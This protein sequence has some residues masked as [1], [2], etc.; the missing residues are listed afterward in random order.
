MALSATIVWETRPGSGNDNNGG[1][2]KPGASGSDFSQQNSPQYALSGIAT[3]GAGATFLTA[4]AAAD[5]VGNVL[6]VISGTNFTVGFYEVV[7]V[8][9]GV[10]VTV[11]RSLASGVGAS[12]VINIGGALESMAVLISAMVTDNSAYVKGTN[13]HTI[14]TGLTLSS[15]AVRLKFYGYTTTRGDNGLATITTATNSTNLVTYPTSTT[16]GYQWENFK[17]T[18]TAS[19]RAFGHTA[20]TGGSCYHV[21]MV[22]CAFD[23]FS[24]A[25]N[26]R[27]ST[28]HTLPFLLMIGCEVKNSTTQGLDLSGPFTLFLCYVHD[29]TGNG[30]LYGEG[31]GPE[32]GAGTLI[33]C[34]FAENTS[35]GVDNPTHGV[36]RFILAFN[37]NF[38]N[39][40]SDGVRD[41][42]GSVSLPFVNVNCVFWS[43]GAYGAD[44]V[45]TSSIMYARAN[46]YGDNTTAARLNF[47]AAA[48]DVALTSDPFTDGANDDFTL[49]ATAGGG[50]DIDDN[51]FEALLVS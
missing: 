40:G 14:T 15:A 49:N 24:I 33:Q 12:G 36:N 17:F 51:A 1:G 47:P 18:N 2:F 32:I 46:A 27:F 4:S 7:S 26:G 25:V 5:M 45:N 16:G 29:N 6:Q 8:S 23:G 11:D 48:D 35:R 50:A 10:S 19:T 20:G 44:A 42:N 37:C 39:N 21:R 22:N 13:V 38:Y 3:A 28:Q 43:N 9:V 41:N 30:L 31:N 34:C